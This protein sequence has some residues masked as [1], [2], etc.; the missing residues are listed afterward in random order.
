MPARVLVGALRPAAPPAVLEAA[1][2][3]DSRAMVLV[4]LILGRDR[5]TQFDAH[6]FPGPDVPLTRLS[7]PKNYSGVA[8]PADRTVLCAEIPCDRGDEVWSAGDE[9]LGDRVAGALAAAG[10][11]EAAPLLGVS[12]RRLAHAYPI[13]RRGFEERLAAVEAWL[14]GSTGS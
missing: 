6:Y 11:P 3:L 13:Y 7:E 4:Y 9:E 2:G 14:G 1:R 5:Y 12:V 10:L 8:E